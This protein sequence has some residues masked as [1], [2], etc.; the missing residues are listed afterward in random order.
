M[1]PGFSDRLRKCANDMRI[2]GI[3]GSA[4][5]GAPMAMEIAAAEIADLRELIIHCWV[6]SGYPNC[7][8][9]QMTTEQKAL[10]DGLIAQAS[11]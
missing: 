4:A 9:D 8:Y 5:A 11:K 6:H 7:G 1:D 3:T 2:E 10:Y